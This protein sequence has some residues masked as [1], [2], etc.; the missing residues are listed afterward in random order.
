[1][2]N[3]T[4]MIPYIVYESMLDKADRQQKRLIIVIIIL[5]VFLFGSN[6]FWLYEW[7]QYDYVSEGYEVELDSDGGGNANF[8]G[9]DGDIYNGESK[10]KEV[11]DNTK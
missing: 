3:N 6:A 7:S 5:I 9:D 2:E 1:M 11:E 8:I 10:G 4:T